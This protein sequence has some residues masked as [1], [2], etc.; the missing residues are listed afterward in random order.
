MDINYA[1]NIAVLDEDGFVEN[2]IWGMIYQLDEFNRTYTHAVVIDDR[3]ITIGDQYVDGKWYRDGE[4]VD[5]RTNAE[6]IAESES[7][8]DMLYEGVEATDE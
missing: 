6:I 7:I 4:E 5:T 8:L 1:T 3:N 2:I